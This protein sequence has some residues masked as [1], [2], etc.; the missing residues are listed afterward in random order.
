MT[1]PWRSGRMVG[2]VVFE[3]DHQTEHD[4]GIALA[5]AVKS[6]VHCGFAAKI[7]VGGRC[8]LRGSFHT[9]AFHSKHRSSTAII[10]ATT[11][12]NALGIQSQTLYDDEGAVR[13]GGRVLSTSSPNKRQVEDG[14][15]PG[16]LYATG[17]GT[18]FNCT[19]NGS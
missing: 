6:A 12:Y 19:S 15:I 5:C 8:L 18:D 14:Q 16:I 11:C 17:P 3:V 4:P 2:Q 13:F 7:V 9:K 1:R 10:A